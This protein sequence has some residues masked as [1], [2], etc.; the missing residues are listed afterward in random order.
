MVRLSSEFPGARLAIATHSGPIRAF[1]VAAL[2]YDPGEPYNTEH[3]R[4]KLLADRGET[5]NG[6]DATVAYRNRVQEI[7][8]PA[9]EE[10]PAWSISD[11]WAGM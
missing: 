3:V 11:D 9:V 1:A 6:R 5:R 7:K 4:V 10:L 2:G 8:V